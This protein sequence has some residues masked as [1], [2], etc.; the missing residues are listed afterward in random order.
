MKK[1]DGGLIYEEIR[2]RRGAG[3]LNTADGYVLIHISF[4]ACFFCPVQHLALLF[5]ELLVVMN[6][7]EIWCYGFCKP[8]VS[9]KCG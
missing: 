1:L 8:H 2:H 5:A 9:V 3:G 6:R 7:F 4:E